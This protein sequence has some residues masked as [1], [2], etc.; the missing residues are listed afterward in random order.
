MKIHY[1]YYLTVRIHTAHY[2]IPKTKVSFKKKYV[3]KKEIGDIGHLKDQLNVICTNH[4][5]FITSIVPHRDTFTLYRYQWN[6]LQ[7]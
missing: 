5:F 7:D 6:D 4:K 3:L 2:D 1:L